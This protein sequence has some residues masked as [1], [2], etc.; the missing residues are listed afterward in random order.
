MARF[1]IK[2]TDSISNV[3]Y[4]LECSTVTDSLITDGLE[5]KDFLSYYKNEYG[6][7]GL[8]M[9]QEQLPLINERGHN[10]HTKNLLK[11][12]YDHNRAGLNGGKLSKEQILDYY[13][14]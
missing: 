3:D 4:Y 13:C 2:I 8:K 9:L 7:K 5:L 1:V 10:G 6:D 12:F 11:Y 14:R